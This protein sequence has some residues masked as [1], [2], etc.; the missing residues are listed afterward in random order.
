MKKINVAIFDNELG[1]FDEFNPRFVLLQPK[2]KEVITLISKKNPNFY[3]VKDFNKEV[4]SLLQNISAI[5]IKDDKISLIFPFFNN[6]DV[7]VIKRIVEKEIKKNFQTL[8]K[9]IIDLY[10]DVSYLYPIVDSKLALYHILCGKVFDGSFFEYLDRVGYLKSSY[11]K[12]DNRDY[13]LIGYQNHFICNSFNNNLFC[14]INNTKFEKN[15]F[16]SFGN[17]SGYR[18][19]FFRYF[20]L[21]D[22]KKISFK[23]KKVDKFIKDFS[24]DEILKNSLEILKK[25]EKGQEIAENQFTKVLKIFRYI[26]KDNKLLVP[27]FDDYI[28]KNNIFSE[29]VEEKIG[30]LIINN[31]ICIREEILKSEISCIKHQVDVNEIS[32]EIWHIYFG[33]LNKLLVDKKIVACPNKYFRQGRYLKC[34]YIN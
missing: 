18:F 14:S 27:I 6:K 30:N 21:K 2:V 1:E 7:K 32:N 29:K 34:L 13:M 12:K 8:S 31:L 23:Y 9:N 5:K 15:L 24:K 16:T 4:L 28:N 19:D 20:R 25:V 11:P 17:A 3:S 10:N 33:T 22:I 26:S